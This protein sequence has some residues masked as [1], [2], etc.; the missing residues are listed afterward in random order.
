MDR[1]SIKLEK[2][3]L[4]KIYLEARKS[5]SPE[6]RLAADRAIC[7]KLLSVPEICGAELAGAYVSDGTE[8]DLGDF[9]NYMIKNGKRICLPRYKKEIDAYEMAV[10]DE[11]GDGALVKGHYGL[12]EP[13]ERFKALPESSFNMIVWLVPGIAFNSSGGRLGRGKG[14]Y[15]RLMSDGRFRYKAGIFYECQHC[16]ELPEEKHDCPLDMV[17]TEQ[18]ILSFALKGK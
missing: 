1:N 14:I 11:T 17:V 7:E 5:L 12:M 18:R 3:A 8:P 16:A 6:Y 15:D 2:A 4:R 10:V 13:A 9:M